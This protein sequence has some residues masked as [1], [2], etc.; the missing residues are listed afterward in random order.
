MERIV[1]SSALE[2]P[3]EI[4]VEEQLANYAKDINQL[5]L[6]HRR[7]EE[8]AKESLRSLQLR[9]REVSALNKFL[10]RRLAEMFELEVEYEI[11]LDQLEQNL[12]QIEHLWDRALAEK[13]ISD[14][15]SVLKKL[16]DQK[17]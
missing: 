4:S 13:W 10:Q 11:L 6:A 15:R 9:E 17:I 5:F 14:G 7:V 16:R 8:T 12:D 3:S 2:E 1:D